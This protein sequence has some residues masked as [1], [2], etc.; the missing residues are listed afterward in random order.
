MGAGVAGSL[1]CDVSTFAIQVAE[2]S[3]SK[4]VQGKL[5]RLARVRLATGRLQDAT[6]VEAPRHPADRPTTVSLRL[7]ADVDVEPKESRTQSREC[8]T[9]TFFNHRTKVGRADLW[10]DADCE[11]HCT[12][13]DGDRGLQQGGAAGLQ[14]R[15][16]GRASACS[17]SF[18]PSRRSVGHPQYEQLAAHDLTKAAPGGIENLYVERSG[19]SFAAGDGVGRLTSRRTVSSSA[20]TAAARV[21]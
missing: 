18:G 13:R 1:P 17:R 21:A 19:D 15:T 3:P 5:D 10:F 16:R 7:D 9:R 4:A 20:R 12:P 6:T 8:Q 2:S 11:L 14:G